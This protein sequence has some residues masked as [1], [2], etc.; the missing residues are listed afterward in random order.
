MITNSNKIQTSL[1]FYKL[2]KTMPTNLAAKLRFALDE[3]RVHLG[4]QLAF[5]SNFST[6]FKPFNLKEVL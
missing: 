5:R 1:K 4:L 2:G 3:R 6:L